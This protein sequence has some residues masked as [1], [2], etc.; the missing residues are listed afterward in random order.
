ML[1]HH[2]YIHTFTHTNSP[3]PIYLLWHPMI[4]LHKYYFT[5]STNKWQPRCSTAL[6]SVWELLAHLCPHSR[7]LMYRS[8][9]FWGMVSAEWKCSQC[10]KGAQQDIT[11]KIRNENF[12]I[13]WSGWAIYKVSQSEDMINLRNGLGRIG[14]SF[15]KSE[16]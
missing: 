12:M 9:A 6:F 15:W 16:L 14:D 5:H 3:Y 8:F 11:L 1:I 10:C 7:Y 2:I 4:W 13:A